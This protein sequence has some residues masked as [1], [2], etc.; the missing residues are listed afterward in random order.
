MKKIL[1]RTDI[2]DFPNLGLFNISAKID[3]GAYTSAIHY[4]SI[5]EVNGK[6]HCVFKSN[7][8]SSSQN[9]IIF[10]SY[11]YTDVKSSNGFVENRF[12]I[13]T[14]VIF[15]GETYNI[16]LTLSTRDDMKFP[17]LIG[18]QFLKA[19]FLVDVDLAN[20]SFKHLINEHSHSITKSSSVFY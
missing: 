4:D 6:L 18:R 12:K 14:K 10:N 11:S 7:S 8:T 1:G 2:I 17:V 16:N 13:R 15:F 5:Q 19:K 20:Q 9:T 3:T